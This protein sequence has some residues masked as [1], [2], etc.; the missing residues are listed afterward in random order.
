[1]E[2]ARQNS[3]IS[4]AIEKAAVIEKRVSGSI[5]EMKQQLSK[6]DLVKEREF[7]RH[8]QV[9]KKLELELI[10]FSK[11]GTNK[12]NLKLNFIQR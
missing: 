10:D 2:K 7:E 8:S 3:G 12:K 5:L 9:L 6:K 1:M 4:G 11:R